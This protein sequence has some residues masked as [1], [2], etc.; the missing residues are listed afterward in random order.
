MALR[1]YI[2]H[3]APFEVH[4]A[5]GLMVMKS[6]VLNSL[7]CRLRSVPKRVLPPSVLLWRGAKSL[8]TFILGLLGVLFCRLGSGCNKISLKISTKF[9]ILQK[10]SVESRKW[11]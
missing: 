1:I 4:L 2:R 3:M 6:K 11:I 7:R 9:K 10:A 5:S 8:I